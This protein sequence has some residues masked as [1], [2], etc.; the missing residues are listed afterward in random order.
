MGPA[1]GFTDSNIAITIVLV[2]VFVF[3]VLFATFSLRIAR[4]KSINAKETPE[5]ANNRIFADNTEYHTVNN[6]IVN[7]ILAYP[8]ASTMEGT[9]SFISGSMQ[10]HAPTSTQGY[11]TRVKTG[12]NNSYAAT[13]LPMQKRAEQSS[14]TTP[15]PHT[16]TPMVS[17][18][19]VKPHPEINVPH[20]QRASETVKFPHETIPGRAFQEVSNRPA[21]KNNQY[22]PPR[23]IIDVLGDGIEN[24]LD[25]MGDGLIT[26]MNGIEKLIQWIFRLGMK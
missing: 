6:D 3:S 1:I 20:T 21:S 15:F 11:P 18:V 19:Y 24:G 5:P 4:P 25:G 14:V 23:N 13:S 8:S 12:L 26:V 17:H 2:S 22:T 16:P 9:Q 10:K 7:Q